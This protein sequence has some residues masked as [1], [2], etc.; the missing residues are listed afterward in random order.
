MNLLHQWGPLLL[1]D[2]WQ[3]NGEGVKVIG[4]AMDKS[5]KVGEGG[6]VSGEGGSVVVGGNI[7]Q[8]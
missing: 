1:E 2:Q 4:D 8:A 6:G 5:L 7:A 3:W